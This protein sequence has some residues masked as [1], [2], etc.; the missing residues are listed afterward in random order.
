MKH[1]TVRRGTVGCVASE[2]A[3]VWRMC[4]CWMCQ[5]LGQGVISVLHCIVRSSAQLLRN[6]G[7][8]VTKL[9]LGFQKDSV[10]FKTPSGSL[11]LYTEF[12]DPPPAALFTPFGF[13]YVR[14]HR[15]LLGPVCFYPLLQH[16]VFLLGPYQGCA[17]TFLAIFHHWFFGLHARVC[18]ILSVFVATRCWVRPGVYG[19]LPDLFNRCNSGN[20]QRG[21][22]SVSPR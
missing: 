8:A 10:L 16:L 19:S 15:P 21:C 3:A 7:P 5:F 18:R 6:G 1:R 4:I 11:G 13:H 14:Q 22:A 12:V 2:V 20:D 17:G 9:L